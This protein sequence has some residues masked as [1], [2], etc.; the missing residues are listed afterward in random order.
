MQQRERW[1]VSALFLTNGAMFASVLPRLPEVKGRFDLSDGELG[2]ALLGLG[3]GGLLGST[4]TRW[5]LPRVGAQRL[6]VASTL[7]VAAALPLVGLAP[8]ALLLF[9]VLAGIGAVDSL[10]DVAMNVSG[11][12]AQRRLGRPVLTSMHAVWS[13]GAVGGGLVGSAAAA[14]RV[15]LAAHL[16]VVAVMCAALA[17][18][19]RRDVPDSTG[20]GTGV[21]AP[22]RRFSPALVLLCGLAV[23]AAVLE[24][25]PASWSAV[26]LADHTGAGPGTAGLGFTAFMTAMVVMRLVGDRVLARFGAV[27]VVRAGGLAAGT[28]LGLALLVGGT[29]PALVAFAVV[30]LGAAAVFPAMITAAGALPGQGIAAMNVATRVGFLGSPPVVGAAADGVGLPLALGIVV[31][32]AALG[33]GLLAGAVRVR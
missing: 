7:A 17:L 33:L 25:A 15:P 26:Y 23:L 11:V 19:V 24:D 32:P 18:A 5:L 13:V 12:E 10:T 27:A 4:A 1:A 21:R 29:A 3:L 9:A 28:A 30:G 2:L 16:A 31:V 14:L 22:G 6:A 8:T 20:H